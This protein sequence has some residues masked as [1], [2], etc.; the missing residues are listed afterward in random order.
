[1]TTAASIW[2]VPLEPFKQYVNG[3]PAGA[4]GGVAGAGG[5]GAAPGG[6]SNETFTWDIAAMYFA[7]SKSSRARS[8]GA[9]AAN[10]QAELEQIAQDALKHNVRVQLMG[11]LDG[12]Y[13]AWSELVRCIVCGPQQ[14]AQAE[15]EAQFGAMNSQLLLRLLD[16]MLGRLTRMTGAQ[17]S[18]VANTISACA[19]NIVFFFRRSLDSAAPVQITEVGL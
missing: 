10:R 15:M 11:A 5:A 9:S 8:I 16:R 19:L 2:G 7:L 17:W 13:A 3:G 1:M 12:C 18:G 4:G 14:G 6:R